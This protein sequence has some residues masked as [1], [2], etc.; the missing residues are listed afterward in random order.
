VAS[1]FQIIQNSAFATRSAPNQK[2]TTIMTEQNC[3]LRGDYSTARLTQR[4]RFADPNMDL[5]FLGA[6]GWGPTGGLSVGEA[7][8]IASHIE[9]GN[10]DTWTQAFERQGE[11]LAAQAERWAGQ[12]VMRAAGETRLKAFACYR[13]AW[14]FVLPGAYFSALFRKGQELFDQ[15]MQELG[16]PT[17]RFEV[18]YSGGKLP[19]H[20]FLQ[21]TRQHRQS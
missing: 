14:Q 9:D 1:L 19:G 20:F 12:G 21:T 6:L 15:A 16:L 17:T 18:A 5:F 3:T 8:H 13:S 4:Y 7:F 10:P 2:G 11:V